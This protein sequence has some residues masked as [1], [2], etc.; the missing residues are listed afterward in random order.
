MLKKMGNTYQ[1]GD[2]ALQ[3]KA[4]AGAERTFVQGVVEDIELGLWSFELDEGVP[5]RMYGNVTMDGLVGCDGSKIT[6][7]EYYDTW[8]GRID[9]SHLPAVHDVVARIIAGEFAEVYYPY[10]HPT[11]GVIQVVCGGRRDT[12]YTKGIRLVGRHQEITSL[13]KVTLEEVE[14]AK[15][16]VRQA[17]VEADRANYISDALGALA[18]ERDFSTALLKILRQWCETLGAEWGQV[19]RWDEG[20]YH[21]L[22]GYAVDGEEILFEP[23]TN[24]EY[25][26]TLNESETYHAG[27]DYVPMPDFREEPVFAD[28]LRIASRPQVMMQVSSCYSH[29]IHRN[30]RP[31]GTI[32]LYF[33]NRRELTASDEAFFKASV[34]CVE[35]SLVRQ[36]YEEEI[37]A[38]RARDIALEQELTD[39]QRRINESLQVLLGESDL[40]KAL[41]RIMIMWCESLGAQWCYLG[42]YRKGVYVPVCSC[43]VKGE[44][45][46]YDENETAEISTA[47]YSRGPSDFLAMSDFKTHPLCA[48]LTDASPHPEVMREVSSCY[49]HIIHRGGERWGSLVLSFRQHRVLTPSEVDFFV[50]LAKG[51]ELALERSFA[52]KEIADERDRA[53]AAEKARSLFFSSVSHDIRTPLNA[54]IGFS[55]L[56]AAGVPDAGDHDRYVATI[57]ASGK[58]L[59]RLVN[60][61]LDLSKLESGKLE[62]IREPTDVPALTREV[63]DAFGVA[64]ARKSIL[65]KSDIAPM[66]R[67]N[68]DP[69]RIR[70]ILYNLLSNAYKYTD[71]GRITLTLKWHARELAISVADTG[72]GISRENLSRILQPF[73]QIADRN[74]RDGTGLGLSICQKLVN[75]MNGELTVESEVGK[76][77]TFTITLRDVEVVD[78]AASETAEAVPETAVRSGLLPRTMRMLV[79]DDSSVNR[80]VLKAM[81]A[82]NGVADVVTAENGEEAL[83]KLRHDRKIGAVLTDLWMPVVDGEGLVKAI[84]ADETLKDLPVYLIT[85]DV[86]SVKANADSGFTGILLKPITQAVVRSLLA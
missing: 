77:S 85:A 41:E 81:L 63:I 10:H 25:L 61:I 56:L 65:F 13:V 55:D 39:K 19:G 20:A 43:A 49:S 79:V 29:V 78:A 59:A 9:P 71:A 80:A 74:H 21:K 44:T 7:E 53:L 17:R 26:K 72:K 33:R 24:F 50:A 8:Y 54:I 42:E 84:R 4:T 73:V 86:E 76:G 2:L 28:F 15:A 66:P 52:L 60:D 70:Q 67:V 69:Q 75:L 30:G 5:P 38:D 57:Q 34:R 37:A 82:R 64:R 58:V 3:G 46:L 51:V 40:R 31:W 12:T 6:P 16:Q 62:I 18:V 22:Q 83:E 14:K 27:K 68:V 47:L 35:L 11:R 32:V 45:P 48:M 36:G 1:M 23:D